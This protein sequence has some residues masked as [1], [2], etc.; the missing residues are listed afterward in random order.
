MKRG[1]TAASPS[2][3]SIRSGSEG[4]RAGKA[5]HGPLAASGADPD[6]DPLDPLGADQVDHAEV[7]ELGDDD[8]A[9]RVQRLPQEPPRSETSAIR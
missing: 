5:L 8:L 9:D 2:S 6:R 7:G 3:T 1:S 4:R